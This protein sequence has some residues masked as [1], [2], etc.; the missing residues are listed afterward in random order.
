VLAVTVTDEM[1]RATGL[2]RGALIDQALPGMGAARAG[3]REGDV[4]IDVGGKPVD[5]VDEMLVAVRAHGPG[6][7]VQVT[8]VRDGKQQSAPIPVSAI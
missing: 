3:L 7:S 2:P 6:Q 8:Y 5:S 4:L 1:A